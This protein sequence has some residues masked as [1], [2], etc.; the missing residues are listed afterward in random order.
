MIPS[1]RHKDVVLRI[2]LTLVRIDDEWFVSFLVFSKI[3]EYKAVFQLI[4]TIYSSDQR[5]SFFILK[6]G[7]G[8]IL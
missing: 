2:V 1:Q 7:I 4:K 5:T 6:T 3:I 8:R